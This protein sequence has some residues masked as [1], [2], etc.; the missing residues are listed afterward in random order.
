M[1]IAKE[2]IREMLLATLLLGGLAWLAS[3]VWWPVA[4]PFVVVWLWVMAFFR[5]PP[6]RRTYGPGVLCAPA[7]GRITEITELPH[8]DFMGGPAIRIGMFLSL[9]NVHV[10]RSA[11]TGTV[12]EVIY[13]PGKFLDARDPDSGRLNEANT[14]VLDTDAPMPG[15]VVVRQVA[16]LV[17]RRIVCHARVG[18]RLTIGARFGL[19][20]FGSR[21]ELIIPK[22][23]DTEVT[24]SLGDPV[25]AGL[26]LLARQ[27][28]CAAVADGAV[29]EP[30]V[31]QEA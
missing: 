18:D 30:A 12:R 1:P 23:P 16:G 31:A 15:P 8:D 3:L 26:T 27:P 24:V 25:R 9:F 19:I 28:A 6:R 10:N 11:C 13:S 20:K 21:T 4:L 14:V 17:A 7:D 22:L 2:G 29:D 5:D